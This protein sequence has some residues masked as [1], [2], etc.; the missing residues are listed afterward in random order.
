MSMDFAAIQAGTG[1]LLLRQSGS[2]TETAFRK[3]VGGMF[4]HV[5]PQDLLITINGVI[6]GDPRGH[7]TKKTTSKQKAVVYKG[8]FCDCGGYANMNREICM[9]LILHGFAVKLDIL[10]TGIQVD[11]MWN[12]LLKILSVTPLKDE[13][14][15]PLV[16]GFTPMDISAKGRRVVFY[17]MMETQGLHHEFVKRCNNNA[18]E[19][20]VPC[21]FY[22]NVFK[23]CGVTK[24]IHVLPLG[25]NQNIYVP[26]ARE[27]QLSYE[28]MPSGQKVSQL[29]NAFRFMSLF[30]WSYRKGPDV[31]CRSFLNEFE[32]KDDAILVIYSRYYGSSGEK[33][34]EHVREEIRGYYK[35]CGK[36]SPARIFYCG[37]EIPIPDLPGCYAASDC[38]V[39][40]SRGEGFGLPVIEAGACG[41]P[42]ISAL[43]TSMH[44]YLDDDVAF[45]VPCTEY[46]TANEK[47]TWISNYY[48]DQKFAVLGE[49]E[50]KEFSRLMRLVYSSPKDAAKKAENFRNRVLKT[51]T[52]DV[53]AAR[54]ADRLNE[55]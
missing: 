48:T 12:N 23:G 11:P 3:T 43:N 55:A 34:K 36:A 30:G 14:S 13:A 5:Q 31:L 24:P 1:Q 16:V 6:S 51:Y 41:I 46:A 25:V 50:T 47:L 44:E 15:C 40:C 22:E 26:T 7:V 28:E 54:V 38:F 2:M 49:K 27:P 18:S 17:T 39:F 29:P 9:R 19:I 10:Q 21:R 37:D 33:F 32:A 53:A 8:S 45:L 4:P 35:E 42:V 52:W 20:W